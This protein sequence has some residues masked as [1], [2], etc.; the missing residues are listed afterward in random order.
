[1]KELSI[2]K[3]IEYNSYSDRRKS[4]MLGKLRVDSIFSNSKDARDYWHRSLSSIRKSFKTE[5][6]QLLIDRIESLAND[7]SK[8]TIKKTKIMYE[9]NIQVLRNFLDFDY[10]IL[11]PAHK[12][13]FISQNNEVSIININGIHLKIYGDDL[14]SYKINDVEYVGAVWFVACKD[15]YKN[16]ELT[17]F[18]DA[19]FRMLDSKLSDKYCV[20]SDYCL[21]VDAMK[22]NILSYSQIKDN[23]IKSKLEQLV[24]EISLKL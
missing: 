14:F 8:S 18:L 12:I 24:N 4:T 21:V 17:I 6:Y 9:R 15:G 7:H 5:N 10:S 11:I 13:R 3:I 20:D 2:K 16:E 22:M 1:M 23:P 19:L